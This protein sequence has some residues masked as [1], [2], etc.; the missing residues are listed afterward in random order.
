MGGL[1]DELGKKLAERWL[2]LLVLPG[3]LYLAALITAATLGHTHPF[4]PHRLIDRLDQLTTAARSQSTT[5]LAIVLLIV[6]LLASAACGLAAQAVGALIE[7]GW[8]ATGWTEWPA[9]LRQAAGAL[10]RRRM[11][12]WESA[13][14]DYQQARE[15]A[16]A[17]RA[18]G[19]LAAEQAQAPA[20]GTGLDTAYRKVS[21]IAVEPPERPTWM[22]DRLTAVATR[23]DRDLD[24]DLV[25]V[26]PYL[27]L[28]A[29]DT[30][31]TEITAAHET[32]GRATTLAGWGLLYIVVGALWWPC[33]PI[34]I[35]VIVTARQRARTAVDSYALLVDATVRLRTTSLA[36]DLGLEHSGPL[37]RETGWAL[38]SLLRTRNFPR[39]PGELS[40]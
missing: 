35:I 16:A 38:T 23:L 33:L 2:T 14:A 1:L 5:G 21:R 30:T 12:R 19:R 17:A 18:R 10:T 13:R 32:L 25:T 4:A 8:L 9:P 7:R 40:T 6:F 39:P 22:G 11:R 27:W 28:T 20:S 36:Q 26:W 24:L 3:A 29:P 37:T 34:A 15:K 31:R